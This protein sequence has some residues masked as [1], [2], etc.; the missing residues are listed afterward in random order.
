MEAK[1]YELLRVY[2]F[3]INCFWQERTNLKGDGAASTV[4]QGKDPS[5]GPAMVAVLTYS[6][7]HSPSW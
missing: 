2:Q 3:S 1:E 5:L 7:D 4:D 6:M